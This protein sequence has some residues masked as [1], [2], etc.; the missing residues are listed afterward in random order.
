MF[1]VTFPSRSILA[2]TFNVLTILRRSL[3]MWKIVEPPNIA[4]DLN[5]LSYVTILSIPLILYLFTSSM[6]NT[7]PHPNKKRKYPDSPTATLTQGMLSGLQGGLPANLQQAA[8][9]NIKQ[10]PSECDFTTREYPAH[11]RYTGIMGHSQ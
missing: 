9:P 11:H 6:N 10:E 2:V 5:N 4:A 8:L 7:G 1:F 3:E